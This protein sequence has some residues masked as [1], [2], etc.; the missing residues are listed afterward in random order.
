MVFILC[1]FN[2]ILIS[3]NKLLLLFWLLYYYNIVFKV[4]VDVEINY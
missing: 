3:R 2:D 4:K 1:F